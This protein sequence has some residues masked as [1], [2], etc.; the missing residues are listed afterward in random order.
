[1]YQ[2]VRWRRVDGLSRRPD[3]SKGVRKENK[4]K[5]FIKTEQLK[6]VQVK[7]VIIKGV[8]ILSV[9]YMSEYQEILELL[10]N[11]YF[12]ISFIII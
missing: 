10:I 8:D 5:T 4:N 3:W 7:K 6:K 11:F 12:F 1:M 2:E 9:I